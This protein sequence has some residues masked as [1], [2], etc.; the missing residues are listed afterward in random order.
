MDFFNTEADFVRGLVR[1]A[2]Q[3]ILTDRRRGLRVGYKDGGEPVTETDRAVNA[4][5]VAELRR[6]FPDDLIVSEEADDDEPTRRATARRMWL[7]DP[8][9]GTKEF[10]AGNDEFSVMVGL[11]IEG[12][13]TLGVVHQPTSEKTWYA[14]PL[15]AW[16]DAPGEHRRLTVSAVAHIP[17][18][19]VALSRSHRNRHLQAA[20]ERLGVRNI[21]LSG[22][23][24]LKVGL[25]VEQRADLFLSASTRA[26]LWDTAGPEAILRAAGGVMTDFQGRTL[27]YRRPDLH[28]R[29]GLVAD[30]GV[31]H[32][33]IIAQISDIFPPSP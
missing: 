10:L 16:L 2:G 14:T 23:G 18:M 12:R 21:V 30:N 4:F 11:C 29:A 19:T 20:V 27:D 32:A 1:E 25:L 31:Q 26:K 8:I 5:L 17:A 33:A 6:R 9:D 15:G 24:G 7:I 22:S 13:P 28:H 3:Y